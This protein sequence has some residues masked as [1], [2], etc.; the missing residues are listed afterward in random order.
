MLRISILLFLLPLSI[1]TYAQKTYTISGTLTDASTGETLIGATVKLKEIPQAS[2][3][4]N[5][6]GFY[7]LSVPQGRYTIIASFVGFKTIMDTITVEKDQKLNLELQPQTAIEE[8]VISMNRRNNSNVSSP[9]MGLE[10]LNMTQINQLPV[11]LGEQDILK[12]IT[13]MPGIKSSGEGNTGYYVRGGGSDQNLIL[14]DEATVYNASHLLGFFSTFNSDAIKDV[15]IFKGGMPAEYGG[16]LSSVLDVK[17]N[18]GNNKKLSVQGGIGMIAS[19]IKVEGP[20]VK[21]KGSFMISARRTYADLFLK[22]SSDTTLNKSTLYFYDINAKANYRFNDKNAI[23]LS[24]YFGKDV[25]GLQDVF[26]TNWGN[27][28]GTLRFNHIFSNKLFSNTSLIYS[29]YN[30]VVEGLDSKDGFK[31]TSKITDLNLKQDF[32]YYASSNHTLKFGL[33]GIRHDIAP[34]EITTTASS[35]FNN[36]KVEHRYGYEMAAYISDEWKVSSKLS[37]LYGLRLSDMLIVGPGTFSRY[38]AEGD[39]TSSKKF[40]SGEVVKNYLN[41]EPRISMSYMLNEEQ[42]IKA[43]YNRNTQNIHLLTNSTSSSPTDLYVM[44]SE[45][46]KPQI[47]DQFAAGYFRNF[48]DNKYEFSTE[49]YFKNLQNQIDYKDAAQLL[50]N[51]N[52]ESQLLF[53]RGRA[54]GAEFFF[55][56]KYGKLNGW[57]GYTLSRT[58]RKFDEI[59]GG[60]YYPS[61]HDRTHDISIVAIYKY[62]DR[63]TFS[64]NFV[65]GTGKAVTYPTGKYNVGGNTTYSYS[66]RNAFRQ[67]ASHRLD[68]AATYEANPGK[69]YTSSWTFGIY[70]V[71]A[72][73]DPYQ[74][75]FRDSKTVPNATEAVKTSIFGVPIPS[76]TWNF[77]F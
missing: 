10:K 41:L 71:Y 38:N 74:I 37:M 6:Y 36:Q 1:V 50:V 76:V 62:N 54:Y 4:S 51:Q 68:I 29:N 19:R 64:S 69:Y 40:K 28:T 72:N 3:S 15:S 57:I 11:V 59:N 47:A 31:A 48:N 43:S 14:L 73:K 39:I 7:A 24:G 23:F 56:K 77:K 2:S 33:Q 18:E 60:K 17:M 27:A 55:K 61:T 35:S 22:A 21:D 20:L 49:L 42:S 66:N 9:H 65:Y 45:N 67:P 16:R 13:L 12:S 52:V 46:I 30:Y 5:S 70:N 25:L 75:N 26:G 32:Q 44:S 34:G 63:W 53:G 8:V 58:E